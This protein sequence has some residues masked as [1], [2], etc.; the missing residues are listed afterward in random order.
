MLTVAHPSRRT[1]LSIGGSIGLGCFLKPRGKALAM[2][3]RP[4]SEP[5]E[6][7]IED[8]KFWVPRKYYPQNPPVFRG[9]IKLELSIANDI[10]SLLTQPIPWT[11][12]SNFRTT[13]MIV[14]VES[15][16]GWEPPLR[17]RD[18]RFVLI[19]DSQRLNLQIFTK[20]Q[21]PA[22]APYIQDYEFW[23]LRSDNSRIQFI[24]ALGD[25]LKRAADGIYISRQDHHPI[26]GQ[27]YIFPSIRVIILTNT[28]ALLYCKVLN[29]EIT[30]LIK[31]FV[32]P[33]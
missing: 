20:I 23:G 31:S 26:E 18:S 33:R 8:Q 21:R 17:N 2:G 13:H 4:N 6:F 7:S 25:E 12:N 1:C 24:R 3:A 16:P 19:E 11:I 15:G 32:Q 29:Y 28:Q 10:P 14:L 27:W 5:L 9:R 30:S 22:D